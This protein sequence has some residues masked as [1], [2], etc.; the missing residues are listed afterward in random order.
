M[1]ASCV[2]FRGVEELCYDTRKC[3]STTFMVDRLSSAAL[4][5]CEKRVI[6]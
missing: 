1:T 3:I 5:N 2:R 4:L 6:N